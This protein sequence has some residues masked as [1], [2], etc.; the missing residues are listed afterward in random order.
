[1]QLFKED[2]G[3]QDLNFKKNLYLP[4]RAQAKQFHRLKGLAFSPWVASPLPPPNKV[5][6]LINKTFLFAAKI[7]V[8]K[9]TPID[10]TP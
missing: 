9:F 5:N 10:D 2:G 8:V 4:L 1:M 3:F 6:I 7:Q